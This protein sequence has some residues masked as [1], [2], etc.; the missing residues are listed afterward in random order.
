MAI[1]NIHGYFIRSFVIHV[2]Y[3]R[4]GYVLYY[5]IWIR[6]KGLVLSHTWI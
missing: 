6:I 5:D 4:R 1:F 2:G 3:G